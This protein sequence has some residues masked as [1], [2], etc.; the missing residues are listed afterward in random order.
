MSAIYEKEFMALILVV[1][2]GEHIF[3]DMSSSS[4]L[5]IRV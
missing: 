1:E 2:N 3:K 5:T 4:R